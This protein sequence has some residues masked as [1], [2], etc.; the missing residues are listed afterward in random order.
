MIHLGFCIDGSTQTFGLVAGANTP[1]Q[2]VWQAVS[3][4]V[5]NLEVLIRHARANAESSD[6]RGVES[7]EK[8]SEL[9]SSLA[10]KSKVLHRRR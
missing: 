5:G 1:L 7:R 4:Y 8:I 9:S 3:L 10:R 2:D 6:Q